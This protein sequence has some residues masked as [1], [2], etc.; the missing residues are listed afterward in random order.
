MKKHG[1][2]AGFG[3]LAFVV[4]SVS[5]GEEGSKPK[6][7][8]AGAPRAVPLAESNDY[9]RKAA[10]PDFWAL[11]GFY[12]PQ[13]NNYSCSAAVVTMVLNAARVGMP[14]TSDDTVVTQKTV[15]ERVKS[16]QWAARV[17]EEGYFQEGA[18]EGEKPS[19]GTGLDRLARI[20]SDA[21]HEYGF[22]NTSV[23]AT[24]VSD[25][26]EQ[27]KSAVIAALE[28]NEKSTGDFMVANFNQQAFTDDAD[29]GHIAVVGAFDAENQK[30][31]IFD[32][33]REYY[34]PYWISVD[35]FV[36]G[37]NTR[38]QASDA[39]RGYLVIQVK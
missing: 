17:S 13:F 10:A 36:A 2:I 33:D 12:V 5:F 18:V 9:F 26:S 37:M 32:P 7:G 14:K 19:R 16:E 34:E 23:Q 4:A 15:L 20:F 6:Y 24:H 28:Q 1:F 25:A 11:A 22:K 21:L 29:A 30:V 3:V 38:D 39:Y 31:L 35:T 27:T 8:P